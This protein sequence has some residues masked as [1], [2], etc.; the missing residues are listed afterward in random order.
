MQIP[1]RTIRELGGEIWA[2]VRSR[3]G[4]NKDGEVAEV[5]AVSQFVDIAMGVLAR[6]ENHQIVNDQDFPVARLPKAD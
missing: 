6:Y 1:K 5:Q 4:Q 2:E 3:I